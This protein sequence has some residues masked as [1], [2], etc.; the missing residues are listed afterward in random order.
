MYTVYMYTVYIL[1]HG[2]DVADADNTD[3]MWLTQTTL[4]SFLALHGSVGLDFLKRPLLSLE[5]QFMF[6]IACRCFVEFKL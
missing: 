1:R 6:V 4:Q 3:V 2:G 5:T